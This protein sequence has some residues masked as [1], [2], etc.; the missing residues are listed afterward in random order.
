MFLDL[1]S[2]IEKGVIEYFPMTKENVEPKHELGVS[3]NG[4]LEKPLCEAVYLKLGLPWRFKI[5]TRTIRYLATKPVNRKWNGS[6]RK[7]KCVAIKKAE[8]N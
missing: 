6:K 2:R 5:F 3:L 8:R 4:S 1:E 7:K